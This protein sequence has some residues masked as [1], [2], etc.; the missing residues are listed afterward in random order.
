MKMP[1]V[2]GL[3]GCEVQVLHH[4]RVSRTWRGAHH[5]G[6]VLPHIQGAQELKVSHCEHTHTHIN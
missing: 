5:T 6:A 1:G 3:T 2:S 4:S